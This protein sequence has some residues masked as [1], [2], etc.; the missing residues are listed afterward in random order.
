[1]TIEQSKD[2]LV[3]RI[4]DNYIS[5]SR[6]SYI[7]AELSANHN[8]DFSLVM[9]TVEAMKDAGADA[10]KLQTYR[11]DTITLDSD[12]DIFRTRK[13]SLGKGRK[14]YDLFEEAYMP[15]EWTKDI[16]KKA[17]DLGMDCFSSPFDLSAVDFLENLNVPA[18]KIAS[19]IFLCF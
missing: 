7:I 6:R 17:N 4:A 14:F 2:N 1:M 12:L 10:V 15:W 13:S 18:Y 19:F 16:I 9:N 3:I 11:P 8:N 5:S